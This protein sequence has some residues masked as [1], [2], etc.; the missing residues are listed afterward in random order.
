MPPI[1]RR[2]NNRKLVWVK[3]SV[4]TAFDIPF[5][6]LLQFGETPLHQPALR[7]PPRQ[8]L[9]VGNGTARRR[10]TGVSVG[11]Q[12]QLLHGDF[13]CRSVEVF[14]E[15]MSYAS[16]LL[17]LRPERRPIS[18]EIGVYDAAECPYSG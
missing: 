11:R 4:P 17:A 3:H 10:R 14:E 18:L 1:E 15:Y 13:A 6:R 8:G 16:L 2:Q 7:G 12:L 9:E 5:C